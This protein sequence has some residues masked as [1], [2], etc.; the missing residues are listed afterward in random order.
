MTVI[1]S[2]IDTR[3]QQKS[4]RLLV[5]YLILR[6]RGCKNYTVCYNHFIS[7]AIIFRQ[8]KHRMLIIMF[9]NSRIVGI[10][11]YLKNIYASNLTSV[12]VQ[13][14]VFFFFHFYRHDYSDIYRS[15]LMNDEDICSFRLVDLHEKF[16]L[17]LF[18]F[19][20]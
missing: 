3:S 18:Y 16:S 1:S 12:R 9:I 19:D 5:T 7:S 2:Y 14:I 10:I 13:Y 15:N 8:R 20:K 17:V 11:C 4:T 6:Y